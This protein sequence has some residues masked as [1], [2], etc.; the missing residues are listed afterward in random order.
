MTLADLAGKPRFCD[1]AP[2][3]IE[4]IDGAVIA[5]LSP[6]DMRLPIQYAL[7]YPQRCPGP[8]KRLDFTETMRLDFASKNAP[9]PAGTSSFRNIAMA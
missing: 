7:L 2:R 6:P 9:T 5:Q 1:V 8:A 4:F 3:L